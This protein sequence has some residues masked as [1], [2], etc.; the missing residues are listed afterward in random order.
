[1]ALKSYIC[2][3]FDTFKGSSAQH[4]SHE[5]YPRNQGLWYRLLII[6]ALNVVIP[7]HRI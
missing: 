2:S 6:L 4:T 5:Q 7:S 1:M 3:I